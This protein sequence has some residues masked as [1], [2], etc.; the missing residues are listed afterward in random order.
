MYDMW[1]ILQGCYHHRGL[2]GVESKVAWV[3]R[4]MEPRCDRWQS[5]DERQGSVVSGIRHANVHV[6]L[7]RSLKFFLV[8]LGF[9]INDIGFLDITSLPLRDGVPPR[10]AFRAAPMLENLDFIGEL[11][12]KRHCP[13]QH[14][15]LEFLLVPFLAFTFFHQLILLFIGIL[16]T[17]VRSRNEDPQCCQSVVDLRPSCLLDDTVIHLT[18]RF[19][20]GTRR[21]VGFTPAALRRRGVYI[22]F[23]GIYNW[24]TGCTSP[25]WFGQALRDSGRGG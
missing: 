20:G 6:A 25:P 8:A 22:G 21:C 7:A 1:V 9:I 17:L 14:I 2:N 23:G 15:Q 11:L 18:L 10:A 16:A 12:Q 19:A 3:H 4:G 24:R 5:S 13:N